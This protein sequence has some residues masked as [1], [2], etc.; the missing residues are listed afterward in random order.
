MWGTTVLEPL[1]TELRSWVGFPKKEL[2]VLLERAADELERLRAVLQ[3]LEN[4][5]HD[6]HQN[7]NFNAESA[8][9]WAEVR[10]ILAGEAR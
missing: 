8:A 4:L 2:D 10:A 5:T 7:L 3:K 6:P 1:V 9:A